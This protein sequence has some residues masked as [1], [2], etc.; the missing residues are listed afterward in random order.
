[1][2]IYPRLELLMG[3]LAIAS[4]IIGYLMLTGQVETGAMG[5][6]LRTLLLI[7]VILP[8]MGLIILIARRLAVLWLER[9]RGLKGARMHVRLVGL[10]AGLAAVPTIL[11]VT[12]ASLL[13]QS[14]TQFW[15]SDRAQTVLRNAEEV[16]QAYVEENRQRI[17]GDIV[18]MGGDLD[19]YAREYGIDDQLF[20]DGVRWQLA[21]RNLTEAVVFEGEATGGYQILS[22]AGDDDVLGQA[23]VLEQRLV[24]ADLSRAAA[25]ET[26]ILGG[27]DDRIEAIVRLNLRD[28][29]YLYAS[30]TVDPAAVQ[31]ADRAASARSEYSALLANS[32]DLQWRFNLMLGVVALLVLAAAILS[33]LW[34]ANRMTSPIARLAAAA[35][36]LGEGDLG[37]RVPVRGSPD[38]LGILAHSFNRM[39][40]QLETQTDALVAANNAAEERRQF[41]EAVLEGVTAGIISVD[42]GG[43]IALVSA[44]AQELLGRPEAAL[45]TQPLHAAIPEFSELLARAGEGAAAQGQVR[46]DH[47]DHVKTLL[48]RA[49][50]VPGGHGFVLTFDDVTQQLTDQR[51]AAWADVA[52]RIAHEIKN[53]L[54]PIQLSAERLQRRFGKQVQEGRETYDQLTETI[55]RQVGDLRR[56]VDEFS[57]FARMPKPEFHE[58]NLTELAR[59]AVFMQEVANPSVRFH[60]DPQ[61]ED[62]RMICDR[63]QMSQMFTNLLKNAAEAIE[64]FD[65]AEDPFIAIVF[66]ADDNLQR[67]EVVDNG[68]GMPEDLRER[69]TEPYVTTRTKG[70]GLGLAI[71]SKIVEEH[72]G[73]LS[74]HNADGGGT[75]V[76]MMFDREQLHERLE[77]N[78]GD[79][80]VVPFVAARG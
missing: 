49:G 3:V 39:A 41:I 9:R 55:I 80:R 30:R 2:E 22:F 54:T 70:T 51:R 33:A 35:E 75:C 56:M 48:V 60:I 1:M 42:Q 46:L 78:E 36:R 45:M 69:I 6:L 79:D 57:S 64:E 66:S 67:I 4:G 27:R 24:M 62:T 34:L 5:P 15:F 25:G 59:Q 11:V 76:R 12:F 19:G 65:A 20:L 13:F 50:A 10:F 47:L 52:R 58:E 40:S 29:I 7:A 71:V 37:A 8:L 14:G 21:A 73:T 26:A 38:E 16:A 23:A 53:P 17:V 28:E 72:C 18:A 44:A 61:E 77:R 31:A 74:F 32:R 68:R 43:R 63:G